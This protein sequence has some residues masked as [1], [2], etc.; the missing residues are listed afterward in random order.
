MTAILAPAR[1]RQP[2]VVRSWADVARWRG[3]AAVALLLAL[4]LCAG[5]TRAAVLVDLFSATVPVAAQDADTRNRAAPEALA[6]VVDRVSGG[7]AWR[8]AQSL[9][10]LAA[11]APGFLEEYSYRTRAAGENFPGGEAGAGPAT[12]LMTVRFSEPAVL[13]WMAAQGLPVWGR[14]R[15]DILVWLAVEEDRQRSIVGQDQDSP[16]SEALLNAA[17]DRGLPVRLPLQDLQDRNALSPSDLWGFFA[18]PVSLASARYSPDLTLMAKAFRQSGRWVVQWRLLE[19]QQGGESGLVEDR[20]SQVA[21]ERMV[22]DLAGR[23]ARRF[24][25]V[26]GQSGGDRLRIGVEGLSRY[27]DYAQCLKALG[28]LPPVAAVQPVLVRGGFV[29]FEIALKGTT[30]QFEEHVALRSQ[31]APVVGSGAVASERPLFRI[32]RWVSPG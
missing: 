4:W 26:A 7:A 27:E 15:P 13:Q 22:E 24:A 18:E 1:P 25:V 17:V 2:G 14:S 9:E 21:L 20:D 30:A 16:L 23:L 3:G 28:R 5:S 31:L 19:R 6:R 10:A 8:G 11:V 12:F 32:F 29:E